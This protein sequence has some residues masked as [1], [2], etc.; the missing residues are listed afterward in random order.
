LRRIIIRAQ[1]AA[2][3]IGVET[4]TAASTGR[5]AAFAHEFQYEIAAQRLA[6]QYNPIAG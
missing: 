6:K 1:V 5:H 4:A 3:S 2:R